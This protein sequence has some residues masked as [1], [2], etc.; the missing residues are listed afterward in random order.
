MTE[1][2]FSHNL[3]PSHEQDTQSRIAEARTLLEVYAKYGIDPLDAAVGILD[4]LARSPVQSFDQRLDVGL[5][6]AHC[7]HEALLRS[8]GDEDGY[9]S[10]NET[11]RGLAAET[12]A[13]LPD[14]RERAEIV[15]GRY[16]SHLLRSGRRLKYEAL[17]KGVTE[18]DSSADLSDESADRLSWP[19][20]IRDIATSYDEQMRAT[21]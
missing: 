5:M 20:V 21:S 7:T 2:E 4:E 8:G 19:K 9:E 10:L 15:Y 1:F 12:G 6:N 3:P 17:F 13:C 18:G 11:W 14:V 16:A